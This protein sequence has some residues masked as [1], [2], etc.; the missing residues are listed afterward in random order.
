MSSYTLNGT[1]VTYIFGNIFEGSNKGTRGT[2]LLKGHVMFTYT[3][4]F[5]LCSK[6]HTQKIILTSPL[7][8][9]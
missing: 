2:E 5:D 8:Q 4:I 1:W 6:I 3:D 7:S 9:T